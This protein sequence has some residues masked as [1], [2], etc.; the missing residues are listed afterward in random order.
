MHYSIRRC[1]FRQAG[2]LLGGLSVDGESSSQQRDIHLLVVDATADEDGLVDTV[3]SRQ[4]PDCFSDLST[5]F[6]LAENQFKSHETN[7][8]KIASR[9]GHHDGI[10][11]CRSGDGASYRRN[12]GRIQSGFMVRFTEAAST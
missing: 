1:S 7:R 9:L 4:E 6:I 11:W 3:S 8:V 5:R 10:L 12:D 2:S